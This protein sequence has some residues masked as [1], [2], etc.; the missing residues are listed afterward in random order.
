MAVAGSPAS[1]MPCSSRMPSS[2]VQVGA[3]AHATPVTPEAMSE[4][5]MSRVRP[6]SSETAPATSRETPRPAVVKDSDSVL[7]AAETEKV[8]ASSGSSAWVL[9]SSA[10]VATPAANSATAM[11]R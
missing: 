7:C 5:W 9:Y 4:R 11:C 3:S 10:N 2:T 6:S 1:A 8:R